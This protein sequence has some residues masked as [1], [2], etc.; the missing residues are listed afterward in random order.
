MIDRPAGTRQLDLLVRATNRLD[1]RRVTQQ[2]RTEVAPL[3]KL[4]LAEHIAADVAQ[5][6]EAA[7]E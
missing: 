4:L 7:D 6:V 1:P 5:P 3:L 2:V